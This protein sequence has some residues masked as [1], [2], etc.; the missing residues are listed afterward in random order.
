[1][2]HKNPELMQR[3][4]DFVEKCYFEYNYIPSC[5]EIGKH[6]GV[7]RDT[8]HRYLVA[9]DN[10]GMISYSK[11]VIETPK[12]R[13]VSEEVNHAGIVGSIPC[14]SPAEMEQAIEEYVPLP[15]SLFGEGKKY[16]LHAS[17]DSMIGV[18]INDGDLVVINEQRRANH[19][20]IVV[21]LA[22]SENTLKTLHID[23]KRRRYILHPENPDYDDIPVKELVIQ[24]VAEYVIKK[25]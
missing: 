12:M 5:S 7:S 23:R 20:D 17:G 22:G 16:I 3:I 11:G 19:G 18:G 9:M 14:G 4:I 6:T 15:V 2:R 1:M 25:L 13:M 10:N 8:A 24:G 21:A